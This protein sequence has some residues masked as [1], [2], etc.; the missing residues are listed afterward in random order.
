MAA[1]NVKAL[2]EGVVRILMEK[3]QAGRTPKS[4]TRAGHDIK[5]TLRRNGNLIVQM[6][7]TAGGPF[8]NA[9]AADRLQRAA[10]ETDMVKTIT[11]FLNA[12]LFG[13]AKY[14]PELDTNPWILTNTEL[15]PWLYDYR[16]DILPAQMS[17]PDFILTKSAVIDFRHA[18]KKQGTGKG[19]VDGGLVSK[20]LQRHRAVSYVMDATINTTITDIQYGVA[21]T[22]CLHYA[23]GTTK[24]MII[25]KSEFL[26]IEF[27][28]E[29]P[30]RAIK[31]SNTLNGGAKIIRDF[32]FPRV[33]EPP[34]AED[35]DILSALDFHLAE[36]RAKL[37]FV[38]GSCY[39][40]SG[41]TGHVFRVQVD[42]KVFA[43]KILISEDTASLWME[44]CVLQD[45]AE[46]GAPVVSVH[47]DSF[48]EQV[49]GVTAV[50]ASYLMAAGDSI[51]PP[52]NIAEAVKALQD[53]HN[54]GFVHG[55]ARRD[56]L[57]V[58]QTPVATSAA[59]A[60]RSAAARTLPKLVWID[61]IHT[62]ATPYRR[63]IDIRTLLCSLTG[64]KEDDARITSQVRLYNP[65]DKSISEKIAAQLS[66]FAGQKRGRGVF[67][68]ANG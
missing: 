45:M 15:V 51:C 27:Y 47:P 35:C 20:R 37:H 31:C 21:E 38:G 33:A 12:A 50:S 49:V 5:I 68:S 34:S 63:E 10:D 9:A 17:N 42:G 26:L 3:I 60:R 39:L 36:L 44:F 8:L 6:E 28:N 14:S 54:A 59:A 1:I 61:V 52:G 62:I 66:A 48:R 7:P 64:L 25:A 24:A 29:H 43:M 40:G 22:Y 11:P 57:I 65:S 67:E 46:A 55:D 23:P 2:A 53:L 56:N 30:I 41:A 13:N 16:K 18:S 32:F 4:T 19:F 58:V